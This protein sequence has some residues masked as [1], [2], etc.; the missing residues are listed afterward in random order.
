[1]QA[2]TRFL[3]LLLSVVAVLGMAKKRKHSD[4]PTI[5][6]RALLK[7]DP[8]NWT[9]TLTSGEGVRQYGSGS[10]PSRAGKY[11]VTL[12]VYSSRLAPRA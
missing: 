5:S 11:C 4:V 9:C 6:R 10:R 8:S 2:R 7:I 1:M 3:A 12:L